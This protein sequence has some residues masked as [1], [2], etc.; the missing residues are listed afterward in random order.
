MRFQRKG[1][2]A[3]RRKGRSSRREAHFN[4]GL[5]IADCRLLSR[6]IGHWSLVILS[7]LVIGHSSF[8][9]APVAT[10][11][12]TPISAETVKQTL[13]RN[14]Y[15]IFEEASARKATEDSVRFELLAAEAKRQGLD[16][17]T[18]IARRIKEVL[19]ERLVRDKV[20]AAVTV[21]FSET[22][23]RAYY[24][25]H[26]AEFRR[27]TVAKG[28][29]LTVYIRAGHEAEAQTKASEALKEMKEAL[30][31]ALSHPMGEGGN[32]KMAAIVKKYSDDPSERTSGGLSNYFIEDQPG[33][34]YP[35]EVAK[36]MLGL[37]LRGEIAGPIT[38]TRAIYL[39]SLAERR[40]GQPT[41]FEQAKAEVRKKLTREQRQKIYDAYC[42]GL[43]KQFPVTIND[44]EVRKL[45]EQ[46]RPGD[47]PPMGPVSPK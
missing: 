28:H 43:K 20:D 44:A 18:E 9:Q 22:D 12:G 3:Q 1:A 13:F 15:N 2:E 6:S 35:D 33:R 24:D 14:G 19:V 30:T 21:E 39:L 47:G 5:Q 25:A 29:V 23:L 26:P 16:K 38:T 17:D 11:A 27:P 37:K 10:V 34:R 45:V 40:D 36:A 7:S 32:P 46:S 41:P 31:P 42:D 8:A 4:C